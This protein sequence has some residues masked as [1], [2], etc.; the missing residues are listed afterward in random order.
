LKC[1]RMITIQIL[2]MWCKKVLITCHCIVF[3]LGKPL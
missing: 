3:K 2:S 1:I